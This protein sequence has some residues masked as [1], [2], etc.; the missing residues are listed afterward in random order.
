MGV[1]THRDAHVAAVLSVMG[2]VLATDGFPATAAGY[3]DLLKWARK[4]GAVKR[5]GV[6]GT[7][8]YGAWLD[9]QGVSQLS[10]CTIELWKAYAAESTSG[11]TRDYTQTVLCWLSGLSAFD[12]L[13]ISPCGATRPPWQDEGID[14]YLPAETAE[15]GGENKTEPLDP[16]VIGPLLTW[17][18]RLVEDFSEDILAAWAERRRMHAR[19]KA[20]PSTRGGLAAVKRYLQPLVD[21]GTPLPATVSRLHGVTLAHHYVAAVTGASWNQVHFFASRRGLRELTARRPGPSPLQVPVTGQAEGRP[22]REFMDYEETPILVRHLATAAAIVILYLTWMRPQEAQSLRSGCCPDPEP[23]PDGSTAAASDPLPPLQER[24]RLR[25]PPRLRRGGACS[26]VGRDHAGGERHPGAGADRPRGRAVVQLH[27][28][29]RRRPAQAPRCAEAQQSGPARRGPRLVDQP[30]G[31][32][33]GPAR[34]DGAGGPARQPWI[35][36][37]A[38]NAGLCTLGQ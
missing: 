9:R 31:H 35:E 18:I 5:A 32:R 21:S 3:C 38:Q 33:P 4:S 37:T 17:S 22:W 29:R 30:G 19:V 8:S 27:P 14:D 13:S 36:S 16:T 15:A 6:E 24:P 10:D 23:N 26:P 28:P 34:P 1:D 20:T 2:T 7:G 11:C 25:R 12:Q